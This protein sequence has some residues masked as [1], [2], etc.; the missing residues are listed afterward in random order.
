[1]SEKMRLQIIKQ[2]LSR[3]GIR[4][5][6]DVDRLAAEN[7]ELAEKTSALKTELEGCH[8]LKK[9][10]QE[11]KDTYADI[12]KGDYISKLIERNQAEESL[13]SQKQNSQMQN[14]VNT[15]HDK[16]KPKL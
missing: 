6:Y 7:R 14:T 16:K 4:D 3:H 13:V 2:T 12:Y 5:K 9:A 1:M 8:N 10:Y 11:I 15:S